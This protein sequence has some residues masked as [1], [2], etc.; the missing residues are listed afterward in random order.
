MKK[1]NAKYVVFTIIAITTAYV[2]FHNE[3]FVADAAHPALATLRS[4]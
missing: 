1:F 3:R 4:V 2:M